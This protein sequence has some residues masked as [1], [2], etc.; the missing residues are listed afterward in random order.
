VSNLKKKASPTS[1]PRQMARP[2][3]RDCATS[4][5]CVVGTLPLP[6]RALVSPLIRETAFRKGDELSS[7]GNVAPRVQIIKVGTLFGY[8]TGKNGRRNPIGIAGRG[9]V[10]GMYGC[11]GQPNQLS[12]I[13]VTAGRVCELSM[14]ALD[15]K[16]NAG[17]AFR[18]QLIAGCVH[19]FGLTA[20]WSALMRL[21]TTTQRL[22]GTLLLLSDVQGSPVVQLP[23][24]TALAELL[25][26]TRESIVRGLGVLEA[27]RCI[28]KLERKKCHVFST[29]LLEWL[30]SA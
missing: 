2:D 18:E 3:C 6:V 10:F 15:E 9:A 21:R 8:R 26:T 29:R 30:D 19:S 28:A 14:A 11:F 17:T 24:H 25:G 1:H 13:A 12:G 16:T 5:N 22:A 7:Q 20:D 27:E 4:S 23:T